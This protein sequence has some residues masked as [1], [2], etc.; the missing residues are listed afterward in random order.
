MIMP[1]YGAGLPRRR[2]E[3]PQTLRCRQ[4][5]P[6]MYDV[7]GR[8]AR[9]DRVCPDDVCMNGFM[10]DDMAVTETE[11]LHPTTVH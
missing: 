9:V 7:G 5:E 1:Q 11:P 2:R 6:G 8:R 10:C 4:P 3:R